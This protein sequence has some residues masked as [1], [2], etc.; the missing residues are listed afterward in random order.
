MGTS[1]N[2]VILCAISN[3]KKYTSLGND[4]IPAELIQAADET[5]HSDIHKLINSIFSKEELSE[6][7]KVSTILPDY[8]KGDEID[9][10]NC[11]GVLLLYNS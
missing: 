3:L 5:L 4:Q 7:W 1:Q 11:Q 2:P 9:C 6:Q 8:K 10:S